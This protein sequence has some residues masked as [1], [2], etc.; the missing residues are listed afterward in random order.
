L[1]GSPLVDG[2]DARLVD[3]RPNVAL[4]SRSADVYDTTEGLMCAN[5]WNSGVQVLNYRG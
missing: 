4:A 5:D 3:P 1:R 2:R